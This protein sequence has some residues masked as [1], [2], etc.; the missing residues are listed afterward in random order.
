MRT[1]T[2]LSAVALLATGCAQLGRPVTD[3]VLG[4]GGAW[5]GHELSGGNPLASAGGAVGGVLLGEGFHA[6]KTKGEK[7]AFSRGF[8]KGRSDGVKELYWNLQAGQRNPGLRE[9]HLIVPEHREGDVFIN[10]T[11]RVIRLQQ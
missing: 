7:D 2:L 1:L 10:Q 6:L 4:G 11:R 3:A 5:L 8:Q 9:I